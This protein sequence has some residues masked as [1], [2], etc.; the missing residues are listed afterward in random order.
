MEVANDADE[1]PCHLWAE[2]ELSEEQV[3]AAECASMYWILFA[4]SHLRASGMELLG[5]S[6]DHTDDESEF[7]TYAR[8][9]RIELRVRCVPLQ[10]GNGI[11]VIIQ[12]STSRSP[13]L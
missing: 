8:W 1:V 4:D 6:K 12:I 3:M 13:P 5:L 11:Q 2:P 9:N 10:Q 7:S